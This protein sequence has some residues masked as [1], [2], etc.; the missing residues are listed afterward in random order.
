MG[1]SV[2]AGRYQGKR[3]R[4]TRPGRPVAVR[5]RAN[6]RDRRVGRYG[7]V[8]W[9]V[10]TAYGVAD[11]PLLGGSEPGQA[12]WRSIRRGV[13]LKPPRRQHGLPA[14]PPVG[15]P[16]QRTVGPATQVGRAAGRDLRTNTGLLAHVGRVCSST[17]DGLP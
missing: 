2:L 8:G 7:W 13:F 11:G 14:G 12:E 6:A 9:A 1:G 15:D 17:V 16:A 10:Q 4:V 5:R 3:R